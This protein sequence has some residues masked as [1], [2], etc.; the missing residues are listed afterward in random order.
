MPLYI[1]MSLILEQNYNT[2]KCVQR[3]NYKNFVL[4]QVV[5]D[6]TVFRSYIYLICRAM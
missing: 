1:N 6:L 5:M 4:I 2:F 3:Q